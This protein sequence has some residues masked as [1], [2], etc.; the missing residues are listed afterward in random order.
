MSSVDIVILS[1]SLFQ[2]FEGTAQ[3]FR[4]SCYQLFGY[5]TKMI[6]Q[7]TFQLSPM[8]AERPDDFFIFEV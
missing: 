1:G 3:K 4:E 6:G 8:Y 2:V 7:S 5:Q